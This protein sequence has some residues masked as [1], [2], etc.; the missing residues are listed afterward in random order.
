MM[1]PSV[2]ALMLRDC[3]AW[4]AFNSGPE[5]IDLGPASGAVNKERGDAA[6]QRVVL[7]HGADAKRAAVRHRVRNGGPR[8][9]PR[10]TSRVS[11]AAF[12]Y[13]HAR[14]AQDNRQQA[15]MR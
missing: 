11:G 4:P 1:P 6:R 5:L 9:L 2:C 14:Q 7:H 15:P 10:P 13:D 3:A 12:F 8:L